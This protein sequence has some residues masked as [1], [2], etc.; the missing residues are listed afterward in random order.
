MHSE[1]TLYCVLEN[2]YLI[3]V[4][5]AGVHPGHSPRRDR[6]HRAGGP[7][8]ADAVE[9][10]HHHPRPPRVRALREGAHD[11]QVGHG[12]LYISTRHP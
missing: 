9:D 4:W 2:T 5:P 11:G 10:G 1:K 3:S 7:G 8:A 12:K 6:R